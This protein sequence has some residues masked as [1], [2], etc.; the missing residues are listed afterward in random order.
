VRAGRKAKAKLLLNMLNDDSNYCSGA[1]D[2]S[3]TEEKQRRFLKNRRI[4]PTYNTISR[5]GWQT[6]S[7]CPSGNNTRSF[8]S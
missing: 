2:R 4:S 7:R 3:T 5:H 6:I 1:E 8:R